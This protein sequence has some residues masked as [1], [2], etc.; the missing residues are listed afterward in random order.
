MTIS[1]SG[2]HFWANLYIGIM[3]ARYTVCFKWSGIFRRVFCHVVR[4]VIK[5]Q[6]TSVPKCVLDVFFSFQ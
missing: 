5:Q 2:L 1:H 6:K 4:P 3:F